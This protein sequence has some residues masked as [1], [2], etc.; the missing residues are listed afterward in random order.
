MLAGSALRA[1]ELDVVLGR[2]IPGHKGRLHVAGAHKLAARGC[3]QGE[4]SSTQWSTLRGSA[5]CCSLSVIGL[6]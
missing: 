6:S 4:G 1:G 2:A 3:S 5:A